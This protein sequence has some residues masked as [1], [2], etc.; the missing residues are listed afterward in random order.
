MSF[1][2]YF[3]LAIIVGVPVLLIVGVA[4]W[5]LFT[6]HRKPSSSTMTGEY[7]Y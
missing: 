4:V 5:W 1:G 3:L 7:R 2:E 6:R